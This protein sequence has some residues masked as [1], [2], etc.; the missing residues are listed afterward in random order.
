MKRQIRFNN[1]SIF[2]K[3]KWNWCV[4]LIT[5]ILIQISECQVAYLGTQIRV[6]FGGVGYYNFFDGFDGVTF[7]REYA[8]IV[9]FFSYLIV[10]II[11]VI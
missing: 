3:D 2:L 7:L 4:F 8:S 6:H 10:A 1:I 11:C 9:V 5:L